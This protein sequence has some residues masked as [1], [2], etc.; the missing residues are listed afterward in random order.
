MGIRNGSVRRGCVVRPALPALI[1][2]NSETA[3]DA[4]IAGV[5]VT[6]VLPYHIERAVK[7]GKSMGVLK[8]F[9]PE[10]LPISLVYTNQRRLTLKARAFLDFAAPRLRARLSLPR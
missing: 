2:N 7:A 9:E 8:R 10:S 5:G 1:V 4:A 6:R 3:L